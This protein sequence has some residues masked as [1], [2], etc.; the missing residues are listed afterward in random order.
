MVSRTISPDDSY[1]D[2]LRKL[3]PSEVTAAFLAIHS[4]I[5][6]ESSKTLWALGWVIVLLPICW[7]YLVKFQGV[8]KKIQLAFICFLA[9]P[10]WAAGIIRPRF[11][12]LTENGFVIAGSIAIITLLSPILIEGEANVQNG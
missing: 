3:I 5:P 6:L 11:E 12:F 2:R 9:F 7:M 8:Q 10:V 4:L 1:A